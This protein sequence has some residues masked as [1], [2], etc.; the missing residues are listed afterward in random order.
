MQPLV[1]LGRFLPCHHYAAG[2][3]LNLFPEFILIIPHIGVKIAMVGAQH[4]I[5]VHREQGLP[6]PSGRLANEA[7]VYVE[8]ALGQS[9]G[10]QI[11]IEYVI[12]GPK[13]LLIKFLESLCVLVQNWIKQRVRDENITVIVGPFEDVSQTCLPVHIIL[14]TGIVV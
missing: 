4:G 6:D 2:E 3:R 8:A 12:V 11:A 5:N 1:R 14:Y 9:H 13:C 10:G 7:A